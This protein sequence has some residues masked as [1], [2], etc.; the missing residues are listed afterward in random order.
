MADELARNFREVGE[1][2]KGAWFRGAPFWSW[3]DKLEPEELRRQIREFHRQGLGG[4]FMHARIGLDTPY[5]SWEWMRAVEACVDEAKKLGMLAWLY[6]ED[7]WPSGFVGG[8]VSGR[9]GDYN[10]QLL[11]VRE[12]PIDWN[13]REFIPHERSLS[14]YLVTRKGRKWLMA[15][16]VTGKALNMS[17]HRGKVIVEFFVDRVGYIDVMNPKAVEAFIRL[18]HDAYRER[19]GDEFGK[20]IPGIFTDEPQCNRGVYGW[21]P[22]LPNEFKRRRGYELL[23]YLPGLF[24]EV[25]FADGRDWQ[26]I[27][28]DY[29]Q[30]MTELFVENFTKRIYEWCETYGLELTGHLMA[31]DSLWSQIAYV[32]AAMPHYEFMQLPGI[33]QLGRSLLTPLTMKQCSSVARQFGRRVLSEMF[34][35]SGWNASMEDQKWMAEWQFVLGVDYVCQHLCLYSL[36]GARKRDFPPSFLDHQPYWRYW[37][38]VNNFFAR[39]TFML[40]QGQPVTDILVLHPISSAW[41]VYHPEDR[42]ECERLNHQLLTVVRTLIGHY[43][44]FDF[45]DEFILQRHAKVEDGKLKVGLCSYKV[46]IVPPS[47]SWFDSTFRLLQEFAKS[48][49]K[50]VAVEPLPEKIEGGFDDEITRFLKRNAKVVSNDPK[51]ILKVVGELVER[52][53]SISRN[54]REAE[55]IACQERDLGDG[56]RLF[57]IVNTERNQEELAAKV[58]ISVKGQVQ[59]WDAETGEVKLLPV[60]EKGEKLAFELPFASAQ[61]YLLV[62]D[63][64]QKPLLGD[65]SQVFPHLTPESVVHA[66]S[67]CPRWKIELHDPNALTLDYCDYRIDDGDWVERQP[68]T[69]L[70]NRLIRKAEPCKLDVRF[71]FKV[72][73]LPPE[74]SP[75]WLVI[76][77]PKEYRI[78]LNGR[79]VA[80]K[81]SGHWLNF[82]FERIDIRNRLRK[83]ENELLLECEHYMP[84][85]EVEAAYIVG[86]FSVWQTGETEFVIKAPVSEV[87]SGNLVTQGFPFFAGSVS[88][89]T[90]FELPLPQEVGANRVWLVL[91]GLKAVVA[92]V[93]LN[94]KGCGVLAWSPFRLD[95]T[96][97]VRKR[98]KL[99][100]KLVGSLR[101]LLGPHHRGEEVHF[102]GPWHFEG[103]QG[104]VWGYH[105]VPFG[106]D[107]ICFAYTR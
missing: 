79:R 12:I 96:K 14:V 87:E 36:R 18:T 50:I 37:H 55:T 71:K 19:F 5:M 30:T 74:D 62:V 61:S 40:C 76:E 13:M 23:P 78:R 56:R 45:G 20:T 107:G 94:G 46:V 34:G 106:L 31:E 83:G 77:Q 90:D 73:E 54:G 52:R 25:C 27:R 11:R 42:S 8:L 1:I 21:T 88:L 15:E 59:V 17:E 98:N 43:Y 9:G 10:Q 58:E 24:Y 65:P 22:E 28:H 47:I 80:S 104:W 81:P 57:Y 41:C 51:K 89:K 101:N 2:G 63:E 68:V 38:L 49:G 16:K 33:D 92:E 60:Q 82:A 66:V 85:F 91:D 3:N 7:K 105:F 35:T 72:E 53:I 32:G 97:Q 48:G 100:V 102:T 70:C 29:L 64:R 26:T 84:P 6:D 4:F 67:M 99:T 95:V 75:L 44:D 103:E 39:T 86:N 93:E 69:W